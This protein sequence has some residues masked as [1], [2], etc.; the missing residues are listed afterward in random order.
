MTDRCQSMS[1]VVSVVM[2]SSRQIGLAA[3]LRFRF[4][5]TAQSGEVFKGSVVNGIV[6]VYGAGG[7][8]GRRRLPLPG[9][10][11]ELL[12]LRCPPPPPDSAQDCD[13]AGLLPCNAQPAAALPRWKAAP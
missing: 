2:V 10:Q 12:H 4:P 7:Q 11:L 1:A 9:F 5:S 8:D 13:G 3:V 6:D